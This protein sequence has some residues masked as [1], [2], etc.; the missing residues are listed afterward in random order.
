MQPYETTSQNM[1]LPI[2]IDAPTEEA[3]QKDWQ[4]YYATVQPYLTPEAEQSLRS[5]MTRL[6]VLPSTQP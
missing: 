1:D 4:E 5:H 2:L 3:P 6:G